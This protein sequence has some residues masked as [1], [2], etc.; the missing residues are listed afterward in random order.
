LDA[1][2]LGVP[3][4]MGIL[5]LA[6]EVLVPELEE[7]AEGSWGIAEVLVGG[8][9]GRVGGGRGGEAGILDVGEQREGKAR[10]ALVEADG[11]KSVEGDNVGEEAA[12]ADGVEDMGGAGVALAEADGNEESIVEADTLDGARASASASVS[13]SAKV[14]ID[15]CK[16]SIQSA[17]AA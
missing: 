14:V 7:E 17:S 12:G 6:A 2:E 4:I 9:E 13:E 1:E 15:E 3:I 16:G 10:A 11:D 8:E 5:Q